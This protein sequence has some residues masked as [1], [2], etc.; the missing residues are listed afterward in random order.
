MWLPHEL[1]TSQMRIADIE[2]PGEVIDA[3]RDNTLVVFAGAGVSKGKPACLP[4]FKQLA[5]QI[6]SGTGAEPQKGESEDRF[7]G[8][9][10]QENGTN[11]HALAAEA[12]SRDGLK[13]TELHFSLLRLFARVQ[14]VRLVT[15]NFDELFEQAAE[16]EDLLDANPGLF[17][18]PRVALGP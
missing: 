10:R 18:A 14:S 1:V 7:L 6:A 11:V 5:W 15:T 9:L 2:F 12:L 4:D 3:L 16:S 17:R 8:R 13:P